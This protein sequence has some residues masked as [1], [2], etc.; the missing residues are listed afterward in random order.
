MTLWTLLRKSWNNPNQI[1]GGFD[2]DCHI[3]Y[4]KLDGCKTFG[5]FDISEGRFVGNLIYASLLENTDYN[6]R[7]LQ[8]LADRN[9]ECHLVLQLRHKNR[10]TFETKKLWNE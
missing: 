10:V 4:A 3:V 5:A 2:M 6:Q 9:K 1:E 7:K 8:E